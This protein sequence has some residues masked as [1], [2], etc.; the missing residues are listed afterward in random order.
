MAAREDGLDAFHRRLE[1]YSYWSDDAE[2]LRF[3]RCHLQLH[4]LFDERIPEVEVYFMEMVSLG[5]VMK[6]NLSKVNSN[7]V[8]PNGVLKVL[9]YVD[10]SKYILLLVMRSLMQGHCETTPAPR[11]IAKPSP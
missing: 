6:S 11:M 9:T 7:Q 4:L 2:S 3:K 5:F 8:K 1:G 10:T